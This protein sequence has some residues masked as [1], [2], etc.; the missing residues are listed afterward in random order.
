MPEMVEST[1][2]VVVALHDLGGAGPPLLFLHATG[3]HG[4]I[5]HL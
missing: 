1:D 5:G 4:A 2:G 3:C